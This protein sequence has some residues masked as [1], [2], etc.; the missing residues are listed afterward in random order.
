MIACLISSLPTPE[1]NGLESP[2]AGT[3]ACGVVIS[4]HSNRDIHLGFPA[5]FGIDPLPTLD[6]ALIPQA[7]IFFSPSAAQ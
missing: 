5:Q 3:Y 4:N 6:S 7:L 2:G 1:N